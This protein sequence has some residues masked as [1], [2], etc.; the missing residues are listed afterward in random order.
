MNKK[1]LLFVEAK[2][3]WETL[4]PT[5]RRC[6][7][8]LKMLPVSKKSSIADIKSMLVAFAALE[9]S[10]ESE[11]RCWNLVSPET[12]VQY[13]NIGATGLW[14]QKLLAASRKQFRDLWRKE[15]PRFKE[16][17]DGRKRRAKEK[18]RQARTPIRGSRES[19]SQ[20]Q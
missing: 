6:S 3:G 5:L 2:M 16:K 7:I 9:D 17:V 15:Y 13:E 1:E 10:R 4:V 19:S 12:W 14:E 11:V 20:N 18:A 8:R